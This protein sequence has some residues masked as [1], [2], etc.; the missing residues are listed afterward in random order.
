[1]RFAVTLSLTLLLLT[2]SVQGQE[3]ATSGSGHFE[4]WLSG[5]VW[6]ADK[7]TFN[8][9]FGIRRLEATFAVAQNGFGWRQAFINPEEIF[10]PWE[11]VTAWC[12][13][14]DSLAFRTRQSPSRGFGVYDLGPDDLVTIV[15][16]YFRKYIQE[17]EW[18]APGWECTPTG[19]N[20][21]NPADMSR[22][23]ELL[24]AA[25]SGDR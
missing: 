10:T 25:S 19:L 8:V 2:V 15:D 4:G 24:E 3:Q 6:G 12:R 21:R 9:T 5:P 7:Q 1:M 16:E 23:I 18:S 22:I 20:Q 11:E 17:V 13:G 14:P